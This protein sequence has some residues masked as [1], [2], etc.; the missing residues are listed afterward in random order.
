MVSIRGTWSFGYVVSTGYPLCPIGAVVSSGYGLYGLYRVATGWVVRSEKARYGLYGPYRLVVVC[1]ACASHCFLRV[2][3][4]GGC[5]A[6]WGLFGGSGLLPADLRWGGLWVSVPPRTVATR[7][8]PPD[9]DL[10]N[11]I[12]GW[13][14]PQN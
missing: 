14:P 7:V 8:E 12:G 2:G 3:A 11:W 6:P 10:Q 5:G 13:A 1:T 4:W 9:R